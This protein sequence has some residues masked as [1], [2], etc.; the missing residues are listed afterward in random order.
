MD[1]PPAVRLVNSV[2]CAALCAGV[3]SSV[4][5]SAANLPD[6]GTA[7]AAPKADAVSL[8][9]LPVRLYGKV[10]YS[11][12]HPDDLISSRWNFR[13]SFIPAIPTFML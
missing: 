2:R 1:L 7:S 9:K 6:L 5:A 12:I 8:G 13:L 3:F 11:V 4:G 10:Q